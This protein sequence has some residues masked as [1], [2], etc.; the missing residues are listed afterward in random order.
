MQ[1]FAHMA[2]MV[3]DAE[4][5]PEDA[6][7]DGRGPNAGVQALS[8]RAAVHEVMKLLPLGCGEFARATTAVTFLDSLHALR[9]PVANPGVNAAAVARQ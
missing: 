2:R 8:H 6:G 7:Q 9:I 5:L 4:F 1:E 3:L